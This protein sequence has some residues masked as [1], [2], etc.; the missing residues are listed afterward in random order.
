METADQPI[1]PTPSR[2]KACEGVYIAM[3]NG[4]SPYAAYPF[5]LHEHYPLPWGIQITHNRLMLHS[6]HCTNT[7]DNCSSTSCR[8]CE[9]VLTNDILRGILDRMTNGVHANCTLVY[10]PMAGLIELIRQKNQKVDNL[11]FSKLTIFKKLST[12][13]KTL[14]D[15]KKFLMALSEGK[16]QRIDAL[17][18]AGLRRGAGIHGLLELHDRA[19]KGLYKPK[20]YTEEE[21]LRS[22]AYLRIGGSR[23]AEFAHR[24][25]GAPGLSTV[26]RST[27]ITPLSA[28]PSMPSRA[29]IQRNIRLV[30]ENAAVGENYGYVLMI[31]EIKVEERIRWDP[32]T[33]NLLGVCR[34]HSC[35]VGHAFCSVNDV[36][37]LFQ[38]ILD[39]N[40]HYAKEVC[41]YYI[42]W[43]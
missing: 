24:A 30:F 36:K 43:F 22:V 8:E 42:L 14:D 17:I 6:V 9:K 34:E 16:I 31:D 35:H 13:A 1:P 26:R 32:T 29:E 5:M 27:A 19:L 33:N 41:M 4:V 37:G 11:R 7:L 20:N 21:L 18:R 28:S 40:C 12:R 10:Q 15:H 3:P 38:E 39:G 2:Q 25:F 23:A